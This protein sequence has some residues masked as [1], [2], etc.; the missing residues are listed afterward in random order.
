MKTVQS[1]LALFLSV[2]LAGC[3]VPLR[4]YRTQNSVIVV[5]PPSI[6]HAG[7]ATPEVTING[8]ENRCPSSGAPICLAFIEIDDMGELWDKAEVNRVL[9]VIQQANR[10]A[11]PGKTDPIVIAF[12]HGWKNNAAED[13]DNVKGF[14][15][16]LQEVYKQFQATHRVIGIYVGWRGNLIKD[17]L[18]VAQQLSYYNREATATRIPGASLSSALTQIAMRTHENPRALAVYIGHSFG[19]LLLER[20]VSEATASQI[21]QA[22]IRD[23]EAEAAAKVNA[24]SKEA[25]D[26]QAIARHAADQRADLVI[27]VNPAGAATEAKQMLD[28]LTA[29]GYHYQPNLP[30]SA[31]GPSSDPEEDRPLFV[32]LTSTSDLATKVAMPI[33]H[34]WPDV[35]F[36][37]SDS[38]RKLGQKDENKKYDLE[39]FDPHPKDHYWWLKTKEDGAVD[40]SSYYMSTAPHMPILQSHVMLKSIGASQMQVASTGQKIN[41]DSNAIAQCDRNLF[42]KDLHIVSAFR[43]YDTQ[44]CFAIQE[45]PNRCNGTPYWL[46]EIDP[47]VVPDHSTIFTQRFIHFLIDTYFNPQGRPMQRLNPRLMSGR[48]ASEITP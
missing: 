18:P 12:V 9:G 36:K 43:L 13:N 5:P 35:K 8:P 45:R 40:Q 27:F 7:G 25:S 28:F 1:L 41:V 4:S 23:Q 30:P 39:C 20:A 32:S 44:T 3:H 47:D 46:M 22:T 24:D 26:K 11:D 38:F 14:K 37:A 19:G 29:S 21:A 17:A 6:D 33:G 31:A 10:Q 15:L 16:A 34:W 42:A 2:A 48:A